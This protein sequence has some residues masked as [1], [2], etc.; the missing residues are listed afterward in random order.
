ME[1]RSEEAEQSNTPRSTI[2]AIVTFDNNFR[3]LSSANSLLMN[4]LI[5]YV[6]TY[7]EE[8]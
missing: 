6:D 3:D 4:V 5:S 1:T 7:K 2:R 8:K